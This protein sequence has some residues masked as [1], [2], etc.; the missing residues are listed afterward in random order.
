MA[1]KK[2]YAAICIL[3]SCSIVVGTEGQGVDRKSTV[4]LCEKNNET[5]LL[6]HLSEKQVSKDLLVE[7][8]L[9]FKKMIFQLYKFVKLVDTDLEYWKNENYVERRLPWYYKS[10]YRQFFKK[11]YKKKVATSISKLK[12]LKKE[13]CTL[14]G[15]F[16]EYTSYLRVHQVD[17]AVEVL[18]I[19]ESV[20]PMSEAEA[21]LI[22]TGEIKK[23]CGS[24]QLQYEKYKAPSHVGKYWK[25]YTAVLAAVG[26]AAHLYHQ[27][28]SR[29]ATRYD[30]FQMFL[31]TWWDENIS[32][33]MRLVKNWYKDGLFYPI[34]KKVPEDILKLLKVKTPQAIPIKFPSSS[35]GHLDAAC[36]ALK[37]MPIPYTFGLATTKVDLKEILNAFYSSLEQARV[38]EGFV[39]E[40]DEDAVKNAYK[41]IIYPMLYNAQKRNQG[42]VLAALFS[43][44]AL[45]G[46]GAYKL[47]KGSFDKFFKK[48]LHVDPARYNVKKLHQIVHG[49]ESLKC[50]QNGALYAHINML[51]ETLVEFPTDVAQTIY[52]DSLR[53]KDVRISLEEK[54]Q[55]VNRWYNTYN[56]LRI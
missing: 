17:D 13:A 21:S 45:V 34:P 23:Y 35:R 8:N 28:E 16:Y 51:L 33:N 36:D 10:L 24:L 7:Y 12:L 52:E 26:V 29:F 19:I 56:F 27:N 42:V 46:L 18:K 50:E 30:D 15:L 49:N 22:F 44:V 11:R 55:I 39:V 5:L 48:D 43:S 31:N 32:D 4:I 41:N 2:M 9:F 20:F 54:R 53:L 6:K 14:L 38:G 1:M 37:D 3:L 47:I 25:T 40:I